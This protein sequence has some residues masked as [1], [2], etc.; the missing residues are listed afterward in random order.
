MIRSRRNRRERGRPRHPGV[1]NTAAAFVMLAKNESI[2]GQTIVVDA[3]AL[4]A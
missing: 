1:G 4:C 2:T 3:G